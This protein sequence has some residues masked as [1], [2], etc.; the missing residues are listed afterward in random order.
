MELRRSGLDELDFTYGVGKLK[1]H[2]RQLITANGFTAVCEIGGGRSP[3]FSRDEASALGLDYTIL[4]ISDAELRAAPD[5]VKKIVADIAGLDAKDFP[6]RYD[7]MFSRML[8]EHVSDGTAMHK[9]VL[10]LLKPG[11]M[12]FHFFP[13]LFTPAFVANWLLPERAARRVLFILFPW[14][15]KAYTA[16]FPARYSKCF[17][18]TR[19][20]RRYFERLGYQVDEYRP[21]YGTDYLVEVPVLRALDALFTRV[22]AA[23]RSPLFSSYVWLALRKPTIVNGS[24]AQGRA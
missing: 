15:R 20:M 8:A 9:N 11:G 5:H 19:W 24:G 7:F 4:D 13:T 16:K 2:C 6:A 10:Q 3:L 23:R 22:V 18:P 17:G 1:E 14:R 12:A 21:F